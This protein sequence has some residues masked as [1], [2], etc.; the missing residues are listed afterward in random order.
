MTAALPDFT[1]RMRVQWLHIA[2][3]HGGTS[4]ELSDKMIQT[5]AITHRN[6]RVWVTHSGFS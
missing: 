5:K 3:P 6:V 4:Q 2:Q 1:S